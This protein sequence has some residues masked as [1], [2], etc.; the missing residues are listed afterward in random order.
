M[1]GQTVTSTEVEAARL[2][3]ELAIDGG[4]EVEDAV[5]AIASAKPASETTDRGPQVEVDT[6]R[7][8]IRFNTVLDARWTIE[9]PLPILPLGRRLTTRVIPTDQIAAALQWP[10]VLVSAR[11]YSSSR[12]IGNALRSD[13][14][15]LLDLS[16]IDPP[17]AGRLVDFAAGVVYAL[18]G[19][20]SRISSDSLL[21]LPRPVAEVADAFNSVDEMDKDPGF[22]S[23]HPNSSTPP[24]PSSPPSTTGPSR[25]AR[26][27]G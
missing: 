27:K 9:P 12:E 19:A 18:G 23:S 11:S 21:L 5:V 6:A 2:L 3:L 26:S 13:T 25:R 17:G 4:D 7:P 10:S 20:V 8:L 15:V 22:G 24:D 1:S 14:A 16:H